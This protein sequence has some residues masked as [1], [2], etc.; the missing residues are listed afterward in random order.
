MKTRPELLEKAIAPYL[1]D[2]AICVEGVDGVL[3]S[4]R[5]FKQK[6]RRLLLRL[7]VHRFSNLV[8]G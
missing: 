8:G 7:L 1:E 3:S 6:G 4:M 2:L 5:E